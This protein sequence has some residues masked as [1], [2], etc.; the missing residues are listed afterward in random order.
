MLA[1]SDGGVAWEAY[2]AGHNVKPRW[3]SLRTGLGAYMPAPF[4]PSVPAEA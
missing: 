4:P 3:M 2:F 1:D